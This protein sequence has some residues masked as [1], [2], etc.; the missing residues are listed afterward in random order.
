[1]NVTGWSMRV[2]VGRS[3]HSVPGLG[4]LELLM[5]YAQERLRKTVKG[6]IKYLTVSAIEVALIF[7]PF[8]R[9]GGTPAPAPKRPIKKI[10]T[11]KENDN[12]KLEKPPVDDVS[13]EL[14]VANRKMTSYQKFNSKVSIRT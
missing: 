3:S 1:M 2:H 12:I 4:L 8:F 6:K 7:E 10:R 5:P 14:K 9:I 13:D 11:T